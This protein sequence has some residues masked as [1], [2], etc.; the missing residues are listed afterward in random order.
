MNLSCVRQFIV[1]AYRRVILEYRA[2]FIALRS[3]DSFAPSELRAFLRPIPRVPPSLHPGLSSC[4]PPAF[5]TFPCSY[6]FQPAPKAFGA[7]IRYLMDFSPITLVAAM[8]PCVLLRLFLSDGR[9]SFTAKM[10]PVVR[11]PP[12]SPGRWSCLVDRTTKGNK[13]RPDR[14]A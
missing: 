9:R 4:T 3:K 2:A 10:L 12:Q 14:Q 6:R 13:P 7:S 8:P 11:H 1:E 5:S